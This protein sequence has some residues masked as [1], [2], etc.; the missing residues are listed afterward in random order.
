MLHT[1]PKPN[2]FHVKFAKLTQ[3]I[4]LYNTVLQYSEVTNSYYVSDTVTNTLIVTDSLTTSDG[5]GSQ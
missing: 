3:T 2:K 1:T 5:R 4:K